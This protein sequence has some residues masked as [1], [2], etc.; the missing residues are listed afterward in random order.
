M[1]IHHKGIWPTMITPFTQEG[2]IDY[3]GVEKILDFYSRNN[4]S[5]IF[6][7]CQSSEMFFL[8]QQ[9][10][11]ELARFLAANVP[12]QTTLILSGH[13]ADTVPEQIAQAHQ[14]YCDEAAAYILLPNRFASKDESD[15]ILIE[16]M[17]QFINQFK[18]IP[19]GLYECPYPY[20]RLISPK[21]LSWCIA[22]GRFRFI[23][24]TCC[25]ITTIQARLKLLEGTGISLFNANGA[26]LL[27]SLQAGAAGYN[28]V[29]ANFYPQIYGWLCKNYDSY[30]AL[31]QTVQNFAG[32]CSMAEYQGYPANAKYH[33]TLEGVD[34]SVQCRVPSGPLSE[35]QRMEIDQMHHTAH[36]F[37]QYIINSAQ[38]TIGG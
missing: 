18:D 9:E 8:S 31:A 33:M 26:T 38:K 6:G 12:K 22:T 2:Q 11:V 20:K 27:T 7:I 19:L 28:G 17:E 13:T 4:V 1:T 15:D 25:D 16:R 29:M 30:P 32:F 37:Y 5:G 3:A 34:I 24:D 10:K 21:V 35:S 23:K 36:A 14:I